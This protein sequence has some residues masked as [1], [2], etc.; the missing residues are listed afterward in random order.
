[1]KAEKQIPI[2][3]L[4]SLV[5]LNEDSGTLIWKERQP[6]NLPKDRERKRW[7]RMYSGKPAFSNIHVSGYLYGKLLGGSYKAHHIVYALFH[8]AWPDGLI[9]HINGIRS[10]NQ[11]LN[12]RCA[13]DLE[14]AQNA[15]TR[16]D[17]TSGVKG[18]NWHRKHQKWCAR[19]SVKGN[20]LHLGLFQDKAQAAKTYREAEKLY[21]GAF[22]RVAVSHG[23]RYERRDEPCHCPKGGAV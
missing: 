20:R 7:N 19:I 21:F 10:D 5:S 1:M 18:V 17:N 11:P 15:Q 6:S 3:L 12:L 13:T 2:E 4:R 9:D 23:D 16:S 8:G 14:N 22:A